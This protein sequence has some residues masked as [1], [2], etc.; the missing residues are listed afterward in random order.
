MQLEIEA[1]LYGRLPGVRRLTLLCYRGSLIETTAALSRRT[2]GRCQTT[3]FEFGQNQ[4][5]EEG[6]EEDQSP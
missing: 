5:K 6:H 2:P 3:N 1:L 4:R